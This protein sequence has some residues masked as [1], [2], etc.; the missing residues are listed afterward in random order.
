MGGSLG[1]KTINEA[2]AA[3]LETIAG[4]DFQLIWQ[5]GKTTA[6]VF[7]AKGKPYSNVWV[8]DFIT[9]MEKAYAAADVVVSR[10]GA[11]AVAELCVVKKPVVFVPFPFAAEDHQTVNAKHLVD[12]GAAMMVK[13]NEAK[14]KLMNTVLSLMDDENKMQELQSNIAKLAVTNADERIAEEITTP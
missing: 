1:A 9:E 13:D 3:G 5:T 12:K 8:N 11:M 4:K 2:M 10:A 14:D 6:D 7:V